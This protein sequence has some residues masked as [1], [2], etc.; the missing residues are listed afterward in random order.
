MRILQVMPTFLL[1]GGYLPAI[2]PLSRNLEALGHSVEI[3]SG[4][5]T[6]KSSF[7]GV[8]TFPLSMP[9]SWNRAPLLDDWLKSNVGRFD[10]LHLHG[11][12]DYPQFKAAR[13]ARG[14]NIPYLVTPHGIF[15]EPN[16]YNSM[17]KKIYLYLIGHQ[18]LNSAQAIHVT[19]NLELEGCKSAGI[20]K[21]LVKIPWGIDSSEFSTEQDPSYAE[22]LWPIFTGRRILLFM[23]R[24]SPEKGIVQLLSA[25]S[26]VKDQHKGILLVIAGEEDKKYRHKSVLENMIEKN[27]IKQFVFFAGLVKGAAKLALLKRADIFVMPSYGENFSFAVAEALACGVPVVTT[28]RTPWHEIQ[29][30]SAG[31][32]VEPEAGALRDAINKLLSLPIDELREMGLRGKKLIDQRYDWL[33][34]SKQFAK[35]Y[36]DICEKT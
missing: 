9:L 14:E 10:I 35:L 7:N 13:Y 19:S 2:I 27:N 20:R 3:V 16:R 22:S 31:R 32:Y 24:L 15:I 12:W 34:I 21:L 23:S 28:D 36:G 6:T 17:K 18:I 30:V 25:I 4:E 11:L 33:S 1:D 5:D 8:K 26:S 29:D